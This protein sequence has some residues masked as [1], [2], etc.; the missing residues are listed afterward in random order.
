MR[1]VKGV[2]GGARKE[3]FGKPGEV[4]QLVQLSGKA[5]TGRGSSRP[6][7]ASR[8]G[9]QKGR[10]GLVVHAGGQIRKKRGKNW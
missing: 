8:T 4:S 6:P 10:G 9:L 1:G 2:G 3:E 5:I 7:Q